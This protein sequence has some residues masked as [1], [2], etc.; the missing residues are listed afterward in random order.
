[1][2]NVKL[3]PSLLIFAEVASKGSYTHA[4][5]NLGMSKSAVSQH[6]S[7]LEAAVGTQ[8]LSRN[9]RAIALTANGAKLLLR[10]ELLK[11]QVNLAFQE[12]NN[13]EQEPSGIFSVTSAH[14]LEKN[15]I[16]PALSQ[17]CK[18]FPK[19]Q[20]KVNISDEP[21]D[22]INENLDVAIFSGDLKDSN[23]RALP[24]GKTSEIFCAT[25]AYIQQHGSPKT[26][27]DLADHYW[28][29]TSW[30]KTPLNIYRHSDNK[31]INPFKQKITLQRF[32]ESNNFTCA[33]SMA[34]QNMGYILLPEISSRSLINSGLMVHIMKGFH[35]R[36]WP[37]YFVH[38]FQ[39][40]KPIHVSR[41][42]QLVQYYFTKIA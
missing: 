16:T 18:E 17:L 35:G 24:I 32:A 25:P 34:K 31:N 4:A 39:G 30:Q 20:V 42:Y 38:P 37:F 7:R 27:E 11:D 13:V 28:I 40:E 29:S 1:M 10:S 6:I 3:L 36:T 8:L 21:L 33:M 12:I 26:I 19:I 22:L 9:T 41:F 15:V 23:Y 2:N 5:K 14:L